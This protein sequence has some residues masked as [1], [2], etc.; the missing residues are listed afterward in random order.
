MN[1]VHPTGAEMDGSERADER[2]FAPAL[3]PIWLTERQAETLLTLCTGGSA[4]PEEERE[5]LG[6]LRD[7]LR[8]FWR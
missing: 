4:S 3:L 5:A 8:A 2:P 6:S 7:M 1:A